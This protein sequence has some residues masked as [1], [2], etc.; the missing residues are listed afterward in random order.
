[1]NTSAPKNIY[2]AVAILERLLAVNKR[3]IAWD[4][5]VIVRAA[6]T[7]KSQS[8]PVAWLEPGTLNAVDPETYRACLL[9]GDC[10]GWFPVYAAPQPQAAY[11]A[12]L[13]HTGRP[14]YRQAEA[15]QPRPQASAEDVALV[16]EGMSFVWSA[17]HRSAWQRIRA[18]LG[19]KG[20]QN[21]MQGM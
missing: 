7:P 12:G 6:I 8:E 15:P 16:D 2:D 19:V 21:E 10:Q 14:I 13:D 20:V 4:A 1:M 11:F 17:E 5:W 18:S 3:D 9:T